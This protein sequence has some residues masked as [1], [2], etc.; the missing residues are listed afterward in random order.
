[1]ADYNSIEDF[2]AQARNDIESSVKAILPE[3]KSKAEDVLIELIYEKYEPSVYYRVG[4]LLQSFDI[5]CEWQGN[6]C[7]GILFV[8]DITHSPNPSW[9][10]K[11]YSLQ[12]IVTEYFARSHKYYNGIIRE[13]VDV[14]GTI[15][16]RHIAEILQ[17]L[18]TE[19]KKYFDI[20]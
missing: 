19:L 11:E 7:V 12:E 15:G 10:G 14:M 8:K 17:Q 16:N 4:Q 18:L 20:M 13:G 5:K 1:V 6:T 2:I 9:I 3:L